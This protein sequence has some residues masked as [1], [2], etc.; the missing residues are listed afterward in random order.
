M[1]E[2]KEQSIAEERTVAFFNQ[3]VKK[4][5]RGTLGRVV[6]FPGTGKKIRITEAMPYKRDEVGPRYDAISEMQP[7]ELAVFRLPVRRMTQSLIVAKDRG[8]T[9]AC[10]RLMSAEYFDSEQNKYVSELEGFGQRE[11]DIARFF[12]LEHGDVLE[13]KFTD[14]SG[15]LHIFRAGHFANPD[16]TSQ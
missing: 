3:G 14:E 9:G 7:G 10:V 1:I 2:R 16:Q 11:G 5:S 12:G 6:F 8:K 15:E 13:M 4:L